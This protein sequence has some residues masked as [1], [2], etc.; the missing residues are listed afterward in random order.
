[1]SPHISD[2]SATPPSRVRSPRRRVASLGVAAGALVVVGVAWSG[3]SPAYAADPILL[4]TA[5]S[6]AVLAGSAVTNTGASVVSGDLGVS[7]GTAVSGFPPGL[8]N[9]GTQHVSDAVALQAQNDLTTAYLQAASAPTDTDL[10][11][12]D[13]GGLLLLP[14]VYEDTSDMQL[15]GTVTLDAGGDPDAVFVFKAGSTLIT[16]SNA[17]VNLVNGASPC[18]VFWQVT[19]SATLGSG[20]DFVGTVMALTSATLDT[21][22]DVEGRILARNGAVTLDTNDITAPDCAAP[23][24]SPTATAPTGTATSNPTSGPTSTE[25]PT[26]PGSGGTGGGTDGGTDGPGDGS[27]TSGGGGPTPVVPVGNPDTGLDPASGSRGPV[28][29]YTLAGLAA[30]AALLALS[31]AARPRRTH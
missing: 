7:P 17:S 31:Q 8:V 9:N 10:T 21:G 28:V 4:G 2:A 3:A 26:G 16:S 24:P 18:N 27:G 1:M 5:D 22:A 13:L 23:P 15:T 20:T 11:G 19:S 30:A 14:G 29:L 25:S 12:T 6:F